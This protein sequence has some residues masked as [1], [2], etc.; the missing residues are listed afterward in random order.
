MDPYLIFAK[1]FATWLRLQ[2]LMVLL[3]MIQN[4]NYL[5]I[6]LIL[7][8]VTVFLLKFFA[9]LWLVILLGL[10]GFT[11][12]SAGGSFASLN[13]ESQD[14]YANWPISVCTYDY[15]NA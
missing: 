9:L 5:L 11:F 15:A 4:F 10:S 2:I 14:S 3:Q 7:M 6:V 12:M 8:S 13:F 1:C